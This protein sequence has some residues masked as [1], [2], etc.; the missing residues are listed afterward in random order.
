MYICNSET[1]LFLGDDTT[2]DSIILEFLRIFQSPVQQTQAQFRSQTPS[3]SVTQIG[4]VSPSEETSAAQQILQKMSQAAAKTIPSPDTFNKKKRKMDD[5]LTHAYLKQSEG[6]NNLAVQ[7]SQ[8]LTAKQNPA[9]VPAA[10]PDPILGAIQMALTKVKDANKFQCMLDVL[11][12]INEKYLK[13][14]E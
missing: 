4:P 8:A 5:D 3:P 1:Y 11:Q 12:Y 13:T 14:D 7:V 9:P 6:L 2:S 10:A